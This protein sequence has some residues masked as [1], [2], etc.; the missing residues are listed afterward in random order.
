MKWKIAIPT[1]LL[2]EIV[3]WFHIFL[4]HAVQ[5]R[6]YN[7]VRSRFHHPNLKSMI[8]RVISSYHVSRKNKL[9]SPGYGYL[10]PKTSPFTPSQEVHVDL[11]GPWK[12]IVNNTKIIFDALT[13]IDPVTNLA[14]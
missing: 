4:G 3:V 1:K 10:P 6:V 5:S 12:V 11:I 7:T 14:E 9:H 13:C 2:P 8:E